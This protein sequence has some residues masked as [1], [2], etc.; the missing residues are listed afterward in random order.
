MFR[1]SLIGS[2]FLLCL[3]LSPPIVNGEEMNIFLY[4]EDVA[5]SVDISKYV[6]TGELVMPDGK[7]YDQKVRTGPAPTP[8]PQVHVWK[9]GIERLGPSQVTIDGIRFHNT[10]TF[11]VAK[12][13]ALVVWKIQ[14]PQASLRNASEFEEDLTMSLWVDWNQDEKWGKNEKMI[15]SNVNLH[16]YFPATSETINVYY[17][18]RFRIADIDDYMTSSKWQNKDLRNLWIRGVLSCDD[19]DVSPDGEQLFGE[20]EDYQITYMVTGNKTKEE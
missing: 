16:E 15:C 4:D 1:N 14:I 19:P 13:W 11:W 10:G 3:I 2:L 20:V 8:Y 17:L 5:A 6:S 12:K 18:T 7:S 9:K